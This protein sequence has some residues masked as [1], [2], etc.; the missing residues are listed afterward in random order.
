MPST[1][2]RDQLRQANQEQHRT[3]ERLGRENRELR[4]LISMLLERQGGSVPVA[5]FQEAVDLAQEGWSYASDYFRE[6]WSYEERVKA[7]RA[8]LPTPPESD[9]P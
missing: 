3:N 8:L 2:T 9:E 5:A 7:L 6:K 4:Q 1:R